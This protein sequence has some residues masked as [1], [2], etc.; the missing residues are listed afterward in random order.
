MRKLFAGVL[1]VVL[2]IIGFSGCSGEDK[3]GGLLIKQAREEYTSLNSAR[4]IMTD[5]STGEEAQSFTFKYDEKDV[6]VFS[7][8]GKSE[9]N[10]YAQFNNG[11]ECFTYENGELDYSKKGDEDFVRYTRKMPHPQADAGLLIYD[12]QRITSAREETVDGGIKVTHVYDADMIGAKVEEGTV[13]G[14]TAEYFFDG[15]GG[16]E[17]FTETTE[18]DNDG[19]HETYSYRIDITERNSVGT[20]EN[21]VKQFMKE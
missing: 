13:T 1:P 11:M 16:L 19:K 9:N 4:V 5:M 7:Y 20:V 14:F 3:A 21:T 18:A 2:C 17:Y 8:Y 12:P 6:L 10:E 15:D